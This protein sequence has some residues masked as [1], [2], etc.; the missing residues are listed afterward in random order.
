MIKSTGHAE[1]D[2]Q[3]SIL[4]NIMRELEFFCSEK[5]GNPNASCAEC[6]SQK[7]LSCTS[8]LASL[9]S[10]LRAFLLGHNTYE[11]RMMELL[12]DT[13]KCQTHIKK[14]KRAHEHILRQLNKFSVQLAEESTIVGSTLLFR[15]VSSWLGNHIAQFDDGLVDYL[16]SSTPL[17]EISFDDE[18]VTILDQYV[19]PNRPTK[20]SSS[21]DAMMELKKKK[22][23]VRGR[24]ESL[25]PAQRKVFWLVVAGKKN[26]EIVS[27]LGVSI[28]TIK[29]HRAAIFQKMEVRTAL[30]LVK[31]A[32][33]LR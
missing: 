2:Q 17:Y 3:H 6:S 1:I 22:L 14:H 11:E 16:D 29:T 8:A 21:P 28:N 24:F 15:V 12:P 23:E 25:S 33:V 5:E 4:E 20:V 31:K 27:E 26:R 13:P 32:D 9:Y 7:Q 19:F 30:E 18:L 10:E